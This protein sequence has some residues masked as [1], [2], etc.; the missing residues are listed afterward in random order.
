MLSSSTWYNAKGQISW[1]PQLHW[2]GSL[3]SYVGDS[4]AESCSAEKSTLIYCK[5]Y[6]EPGWGGWK[7]KCYIIV[8]PGLMV[9]PLDL[10]VWRPALD[11]SV[12]YQLW[13]LVKTH[14]VHLSFFKLMVISHKNISTFYFI[15]M[16]VIAPFI[17][18]NA[19]IVMLF[20]KTV[21]LV[22]CD[23]ICNYLVIV[24]AT[25]WE[26]IYILSNL[27]RALLYVPCFLNSVRLPTN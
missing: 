15:D 2:F 1:V 22:G 21:T 25:K 14:A 7:H 5:V 18:Y 9:R 6:A 4:E 26:Y 23:L 11:G 13:D 3:N 24:H 19:L 10:G 20:F 17:T 8:L 27:G 12:I 16:Y